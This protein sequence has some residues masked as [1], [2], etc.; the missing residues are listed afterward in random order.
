MTEALG[1][2]RAVFLALVLIL[3]AGI[4]ALGWRVLA[5]G[6]WSGWDVAIMACLALN[7]PWLALSAATGLVGFAL[8]IGARDPVTA[9]LP[10][11]ARAAGPI[12]ARVAVLCCVRL[13]DMTTVLPPLQRL[14]RDLRT[15]KTG[16]AF[17]LAILSDTPD[18]DAAA[19]AE[20]AVARLAA[21][22]PPGVVLYRRRDMNTGWKAGNLLDFLDSPPGRGFDLALILDADSD[23]SAEAVRRL[24]GVME[25]DPRLA[26]LQPCVAGRGADTRFASLF[27]FGHR[28]G[29]R[30]W[31]TGQAWWQGPEGPYW[32]HNA[33]I[34]VAPFREHARLPVLPG[35]AHILSHDHVEAALLHGAGWEVRVL[36]EDAG[37]AERH[38]PDL[39]AMFARDL[40]WAAGNMQYRHLLRR[41][42]MGRIGRAQMF[43]AMLHYLLTPLW[44]APLPLAALN[45]AAG[46]AEGTPRG[47][48]VAL[49]V[50]GFAMLHAPK[51]GGY[52]EALIRGAGGAAR[53]LRE[54]SMAVLL[55]SIAALDRT[56]TLVRLLTGV[57]RGWAPQARDGRGVAWGCALRRFGAHGMVGMVLLVLFA[58][59]GWFPLLASAPFLAGLVLA[60]PFAVWTG[61]PARDARG[62]HEGF[63]PT[64]TLPRRVGEEATSRPVQAP[65]HRQVAGE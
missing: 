43:Q 55:D 12:T 52:A 7:A 48:L 32:G 34:R 18:G 28:H 30:T 37:S 4:L 3:T 65:G 14:L 9:V 2:R 42:D 54:I 47:A 5:G 46:G 31:A 35:G 63:Y 6:G 13:E 45:V 44:F 53:M 64:P 29:A 59:G 49:L 22:F 8:R 60:V 15:G 24:V 40:R 36:P 38:P 11:A 25:A 57:G 10:A 41:R 39:P 33:L 62:A 16:D 26:I 19:R 50:L 61:R 17:S 23:M 58:S 1:R 20:L 21:T 27:G 56:W 51:L